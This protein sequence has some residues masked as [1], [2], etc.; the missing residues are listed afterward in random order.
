MSRITIKRDGIDAYISVEAED[1]SEYAELMVALI[2][3]AQKAGIWDQVIEKLKTAE[4][5]D[6]KPIVIP[7]KGLFS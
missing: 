6:D 4:V 3:A 1:E 2:V 5:R 7:S